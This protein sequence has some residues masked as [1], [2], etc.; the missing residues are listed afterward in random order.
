MAG[1]NVTHDSQN[2][3]HPA[4]PSPTRGNT[5]IKENRHIHT[6][7]PHPRHTRARPQPCPTHPNRN[8][9]H[10]PQYPTASHP[11]QIFAE[12]QQYTEHYVYF[13]QMAHGAVAP[14]D[15]DSY[16]ET[17]LLFLVEAIGVPVL[18]SLLLLAYSDS[19]SI[20]LNGLPIDRLQLYKIGISRAIRKRMLAVIRAALNS[21]DEDWEEEEEWDFE[22]TVGET[23]EL[24]ESMAGGVH[25]EG[26]SKTEGNI[27][28]RRKKRARRQPMAELMGGGPV[29]LGQGE[30]TLP[31]PIRPDPISSDSIRPDPVAP[32]RCTSNPPSVYPYHPFTCRTAPPHPNPLVFSPSTLPVFR[33]IASHIS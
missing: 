18:L 11:T 14:L 5:H 21:K 26:D 20:E 25:K 24:K 28:V 10:T 7:T 16:F 12:Y 1:S 23:R 9:N 3:I 29:A 4:S 6:R 15:F 32:H 22:E 19:E 17:Q 30:L 27:D 13:K 2:Q 31:D 8:R 33:L